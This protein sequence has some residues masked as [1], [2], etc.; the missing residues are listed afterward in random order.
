MGPEEVLAC[1]EN[2]APWTNNTSLWVVTNRRLFEIRGDDVHN[3]PLACISAVSHGRRDIDFVIM[4]DVPSPDGDDWSSHSNGRLV[5]ASH[6]IRDG[7]RLLGA[8]NSMFG[9]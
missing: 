8:F 9:L 2:Y 1:A 5:F 3:I 7:E 6:E 4:F